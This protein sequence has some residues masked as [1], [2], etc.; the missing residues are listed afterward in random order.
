ML[1]ISSGCRIRKY[2]N[3][4]LSQHDNEGDAGTPEFLKNPLLY[5]Y[6]DCTK[7]NYPKALGLMHFNRVGLI[8][9]PPCI[10]LKKQALP[11]F[12]LIP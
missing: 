9:S 6:D 8:H 5:S 2:E 3:K 11:P 1:V 10:S 12:N 4:I 7:L